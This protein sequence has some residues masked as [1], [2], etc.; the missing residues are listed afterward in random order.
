MKTVE[1]FHSVR[2]PLLKEPEHTWKPK[3]LRA[4]SIYIYIYIYAVAKPAT[5]INHGDKWKGDVS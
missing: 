2:L 5:M 3:G 4:C 1:K